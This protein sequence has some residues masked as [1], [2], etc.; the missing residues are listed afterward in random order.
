MSSSA[1]PSSATA[2]GATA[3]T[4]RNAAASPHHGADP[5]FCQHRS[6]VH[7]SLV[8]AE[9]A[10]RGQ[11][12][13][14]RAERRKSMSSARRRTIAFMPGSMPTARSTSTSVATPITVE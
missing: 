5:P 8:L 13:S 14:I 3:P 9:R 1:S 6:V 7:N 10:D 2:A 4:T 11:A 12:G